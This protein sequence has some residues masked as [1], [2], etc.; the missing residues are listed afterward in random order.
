MTLQLPVYT[1][2]DERGLRSHLRLVHGLHVNDEKDP[3][4]LVECH[5]LDHAENFGHRRIKHV[6]AAPVVADE[7]FEEWKW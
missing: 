2:A 5:D 7:H 4:R 3:T 1:E 6:H